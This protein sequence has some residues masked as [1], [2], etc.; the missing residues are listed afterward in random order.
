MKAAHDAVKAADATLRFGVSPQGN[1][2]ND[3]G[4]QYS[5][6]KAWLAAEAK[7]PWWTTSARRYTGLRLYPPVGQHP[8][9]L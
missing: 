4:Q 1:P 7:T 9:R 3:L 8:L 2:D 6:V 5:D